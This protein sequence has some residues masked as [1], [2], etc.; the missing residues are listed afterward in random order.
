MHKGKKREERGKEKWLEK[1]A[2]CWLLPL[3]RIIVSTCR[4]W[5]FKVLCSGHRAYMVVPFSL[6]QELSNAISFYGRNIWVGRALRTVWLCVAVD[7]MGRTTL[8]LYAFK[9]IN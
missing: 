6:T 2:R 5:P 4:C 3:A 1:G 9:T 8:P 7:Q